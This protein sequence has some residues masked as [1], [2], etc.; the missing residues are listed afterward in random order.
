ME[1][2]F[3]DEQSSH[4]QFDILK[5]TLKMMKTYDSYTDYC[6]HTIDHTQD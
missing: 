6:D 5:R 2:N 4:P 1:D 3:E